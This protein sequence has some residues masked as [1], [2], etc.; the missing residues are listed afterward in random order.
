M[1]VIMLCMESVLKDVKI[2][3]MLLCVEIQSFA[4]NK[5]YK[6]N[7]IGICCLYLE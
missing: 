1:C 6:D 5:R 4:N 3:I 2:I 7:F